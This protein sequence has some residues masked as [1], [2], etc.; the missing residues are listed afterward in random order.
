M[1]L[2]GD[3]AYL[4]SNNKAYT[5]SDTEFFIPSTAGITMNHI[6]KKVF[7]PMHRVLIIKN[8][9]EIKDKHNKDD[10]YY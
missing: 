4:D 2:K 1:V 10:T 8:I 3:I 5:V 7:V 9:V 6:G